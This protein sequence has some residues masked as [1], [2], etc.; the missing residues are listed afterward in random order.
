MEEDVVPVLRGDDGTLGGVV[1][2]GFCPPPQGAPLSVQL[3]GE[4]E[5]EA[6]KPKVVLAPGARVPLYSRFLKV[7]RLPLLVIRESQYVPRLVPDGRSKETVQPFS[8]AVPVF[9]T[10]YW[11]L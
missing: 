4:P 3:T 9:L 10:V 7:Y 1:S 2:P 5:P 8:V 11:P 6:M